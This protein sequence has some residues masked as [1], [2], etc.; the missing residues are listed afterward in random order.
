MQAHK[1]NLKNLQ[2]ALSME[3]SAAHQYMLHAHVVE[4]WGLNSLGAQMRSEMSEELEHADNFLTRI[5][6][7]KGTPVVEQAK[8]PQMA[9][10]L[11]ELFQTDLDDEKEAIEFY[12]AAAMTA[13][14]TGDIGTRRIF[15]KI[16]LDEEGHMEWLELQIDLLE[17]IGEQNYV[18][19]HIVL[20]EQEE[21]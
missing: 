19:K 15:E 6:F 11:R 17:R 2:T 1:E 7:L 4:D 18:A 9:K 8:V 12:T 21:A 13:F 3:L 20:G 10:S 16:V 14:E 5:M